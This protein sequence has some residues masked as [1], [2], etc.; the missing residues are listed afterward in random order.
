[1]L[2]KSKSGSFAS[3]VEG[4]LYFV[5]ILSYMFC[6][7]SLFWFDTEQPLRLFCNVPLGCN[8]IFVDLANVEFKDSFKIISNNL[9]PLAFLILHYII[10]SSLFQVKSSE[11]L[12]ME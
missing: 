8:F 5:Y 9:V 10:F 2:P 3:I 1:M 11:K 12:E 6:S 4:T 7:F